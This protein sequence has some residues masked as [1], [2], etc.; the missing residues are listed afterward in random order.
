MIDT[1]RGFDDGAAYDRFMGRWSRNV[2]EV[3]LPWLTLRSYLQWLDIG[4][5]TGVFTEL[6]CDGYAPKAVFGMSSGFYFVAE[7]CLSVNV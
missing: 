7:S 5:G 1:H 6:I 3:F 2:G 4:S